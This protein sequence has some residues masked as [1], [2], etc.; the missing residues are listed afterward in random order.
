MP[1]FTRKSSKSAHKRYLKCQS[2]FQVQVLLQETPMSRFLL[3]YGGAVTT[4]VGIAVRYALLLYCNY[5]LIF[6]SQL[7]LCR[8][9]H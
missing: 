3:G 9:K 7:K 1:T 6:I 4:A 2:V 5:G 8:I